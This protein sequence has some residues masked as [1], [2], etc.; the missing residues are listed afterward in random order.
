MLEDGQRKGSEHRQAAQQRELALRN[1]RFRVD[2]GEPAPRHRRENRK[3]RSGRDQSSPKAEPRDEDGRQNR[4][5]ADASD[6]Q[7]LEYAEHAREHIV[8]RGPLQESE[9]GHVDDGVSD[10]QN[11]EENER[12]GLVGPHADERDRQAPE[13]KPDPEVRGQPVAS[14]ERERHHCAKKP[15]DPDGGVEKSRARLPEAEE[16][17]RGHHHENVESSVDE[18][19]S[20]VERDDEPETRLARDRPEARERLGRDSA[21]RAPV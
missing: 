7:A 20:G 2:A 15:A 10:S 17:E 3:Q 4:P 5:H 12:R 16:L 6:Q 11:P 1:P 14:D 18:R 8:G 9:S 13:E 21:P 19:L